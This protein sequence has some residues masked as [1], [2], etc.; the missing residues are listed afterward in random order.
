MCRPP[1]DGSA[2]GQPLA[3]F[4]GSLA[5][6]DLRPIQGIGGSD[7]GRARGLLAEAS[8]RRRLE[9]DLHNGVQSE[10]VALIVKLAVAQQSADTPPGLADM[11]AGLEARAQAA[12]DAVRNIARGIYSPVLADF[13]VRDALRAQAART[14]VRVM[15][16]GTAPRSTDEAEEAVYFACSE[17]IQNVAKHAG[18]GSRVTVRFQHQHSSLTVRV[19]DDGRGF[20]PDHTPGGAGLQNIRDRIQDLGGTFTLASA[21]GRGTALTLALPWPPAAEPGR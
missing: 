17:A 19:A 6:G 1:L 10:L 3:R 13:G 21:P 4:D 5:V 2:S 12:L 7:S 14:A 8:K 16:V 9:R 18:A 11:L 20:D 15:L